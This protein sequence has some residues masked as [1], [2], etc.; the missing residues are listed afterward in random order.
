MIRSMPGRAAAMSARRASSSTSTIASRGF[1]S[2]GHIACAGV[3]IPLPINWRLPDAPAWGAA[4]KQNDRDNFNHSMAVAM[5]L[6][7]MPRHDNRVELDDEVK[8]AWG[9]PVA[10]ITTYAHENDLKQGR[11]LIDRGGGHPRGGRREAR[12]EGLCRP[13]HRQLLTPARHGPHGRRSRRPRCLT[14][15]AA[16]MTSKP[17]R[18]RRLAIPD[19]DRRQSDADDHGQRL[20]HCGESGRAARRNWLKRPMASALSRQINTA[21]FGFDFPPSAAAIYEQ[22]Q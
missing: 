8:D 13:R 12:A 17:L 10:R 21:I 14:D 22:K 20:A 7:D 3:G 11:F 15:G 4:A 9:L 1:V 5:V 19:R 18:G 6:H 16:R 2:G